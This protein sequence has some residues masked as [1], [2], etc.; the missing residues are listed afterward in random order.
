MFAQKV[1]T[2]WF[3]ALAVTAFAAAGSAPA[4]GSEKFVVSFRLTNWQSAHF[5]D[6]AMAKTHRDTV[7]RL[8]CEVKEDAHSGHTDVAYRLMR[9]RRLSL[10]SQDEAHQLAHWLS[11]NGFETLFLQPAQSGHLETVAFRLP[12]A[13]SRHFDSADQANSNADTIRMLGCEVKQGSHGGHHDVSYRCPQ[14]RVIGLEDPAEAHEWERW[15]KRN[16][17]ETRHEH[18]N[19]HDAQDHK[20]HDHEGHDHG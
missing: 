17:F 2:G 16:G 11:D 14:W 5:D 20:G 3:A 15:L 1:K 6:A 19:G 9:W 4:W 12:K 13:K 7:R 18:H 8:G 10:K